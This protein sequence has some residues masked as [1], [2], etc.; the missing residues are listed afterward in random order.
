MTNTLTK[1]EQFPRDP[2]RLRVEPTKSA[3]LAL[4]STAKDGAGDAG[5]IPDP[6]GGQGAPDD[7]GH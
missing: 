4:G 5:T 1:W 7:A 3:P 2:V 6:F